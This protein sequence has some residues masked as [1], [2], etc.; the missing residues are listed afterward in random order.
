MHT[1]KAGVLLERGLYRHFG[2]YA[3][4]LA[5]G[6]NPNETSDSA[7][8]Y[9]AR[10]I[11]DWRM[12][13]DSEDDGISRTLRCY[14]LHEQLSSDA[15]AAA[16]A[17]VRERVDGTVPVVDVGAN[18][19]YYALLEAAVLGEQARVFAIEPAPDNLELLTRNVRSNG[20]ETTVEV[21]QCAI[22][23]TNEPVELRLSNYSN[24]HTVRELPGDV[25]RSGCQH[26]RERVEVPQRTVDRF[27]ADRGLSPADVAAVR[28]D[29]EGYETAVVEG[30]EGVLDADGPLVVFVELHPVLSDAELD[31]V[32][33]AFDR[34]GLSVVSAVVDESVAGTNHTM[35]WRGVDL[36]AESF[37]EVAAAIRE[38]DRP[39][40]LV[41]SR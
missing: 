5:S 2:G 36:H 33:S 40:E 35:K 32:L 8:R 16:L 6:W 10:D 19:G 21:E 24:R 41:A 30:M 37:E 34:G 26:D 22:G 27:V 28:M 25:W 39:V 17:D 11:H 12:W 15:F 4:E 29:L 13:L 9:V 18:I 14:G 31:D 1:Q 23:G 20:L 7:A 38:T 3:I